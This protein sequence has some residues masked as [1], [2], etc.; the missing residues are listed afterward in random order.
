MY[1]FGENNSG[2]KTN[3]YMGF[4]AGY[5]AGPISVHGAY[6][7]T[8]GATDAADHKAMNFGASFDAGVVKATLVYAQ[9][10]NGAGLKVTAI[11][12]GIL[13]PVGAGVIRASYARHDI[14]DSDNDWN[15]IAVGYIHNLSKR[16]TVYATYAR[17]GNKGTQ[18]RAVANNGLS[19]PA[20]TPGGNLMPAGAT[21]PDHK[22][23]PLG[24][25]F[26]WARG[27][28]RWWFSG[29]PAAATRRGT[30]RRHAPGRG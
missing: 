12:P 23:P 24:A 16:T 27:R 7:K 29:P 28:C 6:G 17:V 18:T 19:A 22:K 30:G 15:K 8:E 21:R 10:K 5:S 20:V 2:I 11:E 3:N 9:E 25:A 13:V 14:K 4:R 1:A 26:S